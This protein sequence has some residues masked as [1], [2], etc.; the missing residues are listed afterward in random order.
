MSSQS[1]ALDKPALKQD[2]V[3]QA[4]LRDELERVNCWK[5]A[6]P[7]RPLAQTLR[8]TGNRETAYHCD[9]LFVPAAWRERIRMCDVVTGWEELSDHNP[10]VVDID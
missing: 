10:V 7:D 9:G 8:W 3:I 2:M 5:V 6:N 1:L 4:R